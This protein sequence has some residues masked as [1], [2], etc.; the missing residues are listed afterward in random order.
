M[1]V[2]GNAHGVAG[3]LDALR[4]RVVLEAGARVVARVVV[5]NNDAAG[6]VGDGVLEDDFLVAHGGC[7]AAY[8][9]QLAAFHVLGAVEQQY[10]HLLVLLVEHEGAQV[11]VGGVGVG[12]LVVV[13]EL[14]ALEAPR[15]LYSGKDFHRFH[16]AHAAI[17]AREVAVSA[18][19]YLVDFVV[20]VTQDALAQLHHALA[21]AAAA[22]DDCKEL[23]R[24]QG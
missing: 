17:H 6:Q 16:F 9:H 12:D 11:A 24:R 8:A 21:T 4:E 18:S 22:Q 2:E 5:G 19:G 3:A 20:M 23:G 14:L 15:Y 10:P 1:V 13:V 7:C